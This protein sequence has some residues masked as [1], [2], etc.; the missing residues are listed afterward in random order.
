MTI[1][2]LILIFLA[3]AISK[4]VFLR[5]EF[6]YLG[7]LR[8]K[9]GII[10]KARQYAKKC[11][12]ETNQTYDGK[13]YFDAHVKKVVNVAL[14]FIHLIPESKRDIVIS[15]AYTHDVQE[16]CR[17]T[18]NDVI[19]ATN[20]EVAELSYALTNEKGRNRKERANDKYYAGIKNT[21]YATFIKCCD[22]IAN[23]ESNCTKKS[24]TMLKK[25]K[26][27]NAEFK[28]KLYDKQYDELFQHLDLI[29]S[30]KKQTT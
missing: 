11:H 9:Y 30:D 26:E 4:H 5:I 8:D 29:L 18:L 15:G 28:V 27:E 7:Y 22:R 20:N 6:I 12:T 2:Y 14:K 10:E 25:Y 24:N 23:I 16:D 17:Q 3:A 1:L 19:K 13:P 21:P